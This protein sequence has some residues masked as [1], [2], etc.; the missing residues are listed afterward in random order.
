MDLGDE[1]TTD[2]SSA[3]AEGPAASITRGRARYP[4]NCPAPDPVVSE[5]GDRGLRIEL[6]AEAASVTA[7]RQLVREHAAG[8]GLTPEQVFDLATVVTEACGNVVRY[9][10]REGPGGP[11]EVT[12][13]EEGDELDLRVRDHGRGICPRPGGGP[14]GVGLGLPLIGALSKT[15]CLRSELGSGTELGIRFAIRDAG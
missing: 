2:T 5:S 7:I 14:Q 10:Y 8:L 1:Q 11:L 15:F 13:R 12:M 3:K 6:P 4:L 9:A